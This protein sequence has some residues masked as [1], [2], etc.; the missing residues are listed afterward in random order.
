MTRKL[1]DAII[2]HQ[3]MFKHM[4]FGALKIELSREGGR[5]RVWNSFECSYSRALMNVR[6]NR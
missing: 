1:E 5:A 6:G 3:E 4:G 2:L